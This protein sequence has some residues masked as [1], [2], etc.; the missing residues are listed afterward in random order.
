METGVSVSLRVVVERVEQQ[1][2]H[3][4]GGVKEREQSLR[5]RGDCD[6]ASRGWL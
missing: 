1:S 3:G 6:M 5:V 2:P 4:C